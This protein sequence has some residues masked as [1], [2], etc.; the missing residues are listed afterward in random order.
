MS[1]FWTDCLARFESELPAQQFNAWIKSLRVESDEDG[2]HLR[3]FAPNGFILKW[4]RERY[5]DRV[6]VLSR[7]FFKEPVTIDL[8]LDETPS[9]LVQDTVVDGLA[10]L[11]AANIITAGNS[12][13]LSGEE[14]LNKHP[15]KRDDPGDHGAQAHFRL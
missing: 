10:G 8:M 3:L 11:G 4:V 13:V 6:E 14:R 7:Q 12:P 1:L 5:L 15:T 2:R 9:S